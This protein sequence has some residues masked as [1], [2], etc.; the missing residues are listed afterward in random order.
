MYFFFLMIRRPPRSTLFP[1]TTLFRSPAFGPRQLRNQHV[2]VALLGSGEVAELELE[3]RV[4]E[5]VVQVLHVE[6]LPRQQQAQ[7]PAVHFFHLNAESCF[8]IR[9]LNSRSPPSSV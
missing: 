9:D 4:P 5:P 1:Y 6:E 7:L 8:F 2:V 3:V